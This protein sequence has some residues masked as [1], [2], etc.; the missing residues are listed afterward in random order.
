MRLLVEAGANKG[1]KD[2]VR[3]SSEHM[4]SLYSTLCAFDFIYHGKSYGSCALA[5]MSLVIMIVSSFWNSHVL[6][7]LQEGLTAL[8]HALSRGFSN[9]VALLTANDFAS[10][11]FVTAA[12]S[13]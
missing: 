6:M 9:I 11:G 5:I 13:S 1:T 3:E 10:A 4:F 8:A 7:N 2:S 12:D